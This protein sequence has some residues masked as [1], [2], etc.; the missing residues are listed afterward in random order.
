[1]NKTNLK[2][3]VNKELPQY[4]NQLL[5]DA[6]FYAKVGDPAMDNSLDESLEDR[7]NCRELEK[8]LKEVEKL[9]LKVDKGL[10]GPIK[11]EIKEIRDLYWGITREEYG[12]GQFSISIDFSRNPKATKAK[13]KIDYNFSKEVSKRMEEGDRRALKAWKKVKDIIITY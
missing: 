8:K 13:A 1:M 12:P 4:I 5:T 9:Y 10:R 7:P 2:Y 11:K 3:T 6:R